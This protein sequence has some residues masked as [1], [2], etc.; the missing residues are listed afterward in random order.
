MI[1]TLVVDD[2]AMAVSVHRQFTERVG[3]FQVVGEATSGAAALRALETVRPDLILLDMYLPDLGGIDILRRIRA[4]NAAAVDVIAIT[5]AKDVDVLRSAMHLGVV[6]YIVKPFT[7]RIFRERL[8]SY[9]AARTQLDRMSVPAQRDIDRLYGRLRSSGEQSLPKGISDTTLDHVTETLR[10]TQDGVT[11]TELAER[12][13]FSQAVSR[14]YLKFL[15]DTGA[16]QIVPRYGTAG[17]P[18]HSYRWAENRDR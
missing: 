4:S 3:G 11:A 14:R 18:E 10:K 2:D 7:F 17:R 16:V 13:G 15:H 9:A 6:H 1:R 8:D 5:S 12:I